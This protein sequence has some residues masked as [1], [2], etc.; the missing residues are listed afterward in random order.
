MKGSRDLIRE[1][2]NASIGVKQAILSDEGLLQNI[3]SF[4][5]VLTEVLRQGNKVLLFGNG[6]SAADSQHLAAEFVGHFMVERGPLP[7]IALT[8]DTSVLTAI[9]ND[10]DF[11]DVFARQVQA[12][13]SPGDVAVGLSTSGNSPN[14]F[15]GLEAAR[16]GGLKTVGLTGQSG[17]ETAAVADTLVAIPSGDTQRVQEAHIT[18]GHIVCEI[19]ERS[20]YPAA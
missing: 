11:A 15:R 13:G 8:V 4:A 10:Y 12:L 9:S 7:A 2:L 1:G 16:R 18:I 5:D 3:E 19:V 17:G 14:V 6:G 20:L